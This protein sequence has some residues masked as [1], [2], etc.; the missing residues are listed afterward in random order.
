MAQQLSTETELCNL[1]LS[2]FAGKS[3]AAMDEN[4]REAEACRTAF[5]TA[6]AFVLSDFDWKFASTKKAGVAIVLDQVP[7]LATV[8]LDGWAYLYEYPQ[9]CAKIREILTHDQFANSTPFGY[10]NVNGAAF[11]PAAVDAYYVSPASNSHT[12]SNERGFGDNRGPEIPFNIAAIG[13]TKY[14]F[15]DVPNAR[16]RYTRFMD[17]VIG[18][19]PEFSL[20]FSFYLASLIA[21]RLTRKFEV[22]GNMLKM[23]QEMKPK[24]EAQNANETTNINRDPPAPW[25]LARGGD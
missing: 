19:P 18:Y 16:F 24:A 5:G 12:L 15:C 25:T 21:Y 6:L 9:D 7:E 22:S 2:H 20:T 10:G 1:A 14:V 11:G 13:S 4:S 23:Y 17:N 8:D 3:I